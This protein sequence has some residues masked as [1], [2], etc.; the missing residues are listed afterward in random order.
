[1]VWCL[2]FG[3]KKYLDSVA[4]MLSSENSLTSLRIDSV[5]TRQMLLF[6]FYF[7]SLPF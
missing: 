5:K 2:I 4:T 1:M 6:L 7:F 3:F